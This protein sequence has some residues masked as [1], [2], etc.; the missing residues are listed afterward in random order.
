MILQKCF[1]RNP[2]GVVRVGV[3]RVHWQ[4]REQAIEYKALLV[5]M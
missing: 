3:V 5:E 4:N 2:G 1:R